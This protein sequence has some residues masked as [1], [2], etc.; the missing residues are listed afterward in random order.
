MD[1]LEVPYYKDN[2]FN[3]GEMNQDVFYGFKVNFEFF[4]RL[5]D[6]FCLGFR[7]E[8]ESF[9]LRRYQ[10]QAFKLIYLFS[11]ERTNK[12]FDQGKE[13]FVLGTSTGKVKNEIMSI[14][15]MVAKERKNIILA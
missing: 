8:Q 13:S 15:Y 9:K 6:R 11:A 3:L 14:E 12:F 2:R 1:Q 10:F 7:F 5:V 4:L